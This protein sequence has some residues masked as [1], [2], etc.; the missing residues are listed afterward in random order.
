MKIRA[1]V[2]GATGMVGEGV[3]HE[4]LL[5]PDVESVLIVNRRPS[6]F[7]HPKLKELIHADF[8]D[9]AAVR[10]E[11]KGYNACFF[12]SGVSSVG[13][14]E[15][16]YSRVT[17]D[18]TMHFG[19][20]LS[21]LNKDMVFIYVS[22][23]GTDSTASGRTMW[24]RVKGRTENDLLKLP[25]A[26]AY[27]FRPG[28]MHPTP[29]LKNTLKLVKAVSWLYPVLRPVFPGVVSTLK[30]VGLAMIHAVERRPEKQILEVRDIVELAK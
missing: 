12:C 14:T 23:S 21:E 7:T 5:H 9:L 3:M 1:I 11:L 16:E 25:F 8:S 18:L 29:G 22:G 30:E 26:K 15:E 13:M 20:T 19:R 17:Y 27:M 2:T 10:A 4:C 24:A 28:Y 6:G